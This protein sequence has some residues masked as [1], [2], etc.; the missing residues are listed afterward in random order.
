MAKGNK[1]RKKG[2]AQ[3]SA[4]Y[5]TVKSQF[6][7]LAGLP[8]RTAAKS[9]AIIDENDNEDD[10]NDDLYVE[11]D[12][13][14]VLVTGRVVLTDLPIA[15]SYQLYH[16]WLTRDVSIMQWG[17]DNDIQMIFADNEENDVEVDQNQLGRMKRNFPDEL[18]KARDIMSEPCLE[19]IFGVVRDVNKFEGRLTYRALKKFNNLSSKLEQEAVLFTIVSGAML[20]RVSLRPGDDLEYQIQRITNGNIW[21]FDGVVDLNSHHTIP[22]PGVYAAYLWVANDPHFFEFNTPSAYMLLPRPPNFNTYERFLKGWIKGILQ[23]NVQA[24]RNLRHRPKDNRVYMQNVSAI[25]GSFSPGMA[26]RNLRLGD[27]LKSWWAD[28]EGYRKLLHHVEY[29]LVFEHRRTQCAV[30]CDFEEAAEMNRQAKDFCAQNPML[31]PWIPSPDKRMDLYDPGDPLREKYEREMR[32]QRLREERSLHPQHFHT[33][34]VDENDKGSDND[35]GGHNSDDDESRSSDNRKRRSGTDHSGGAQT[36][37]QNRSMRNA[38]ALSNPRSDPPKSP[39]PVTRQLFATT[40]AVTGMTQG[41][42]GSFSFKSLEDLQRFINSQPTASVGTP[43]NAPASMSSQMVPILTV[44]SKQLRGPDP[45]VPFGPKIYEQLR[46]FKDFLEKANVMLDTPEYFHLR[47]ERIDS[48]WSSHLDLVL[49]YYE[50]PGYWKTLNHVTFFRILFHSLVQAEDTPK[51]TGYVE[52][53]EQWIE[54]EFSKV[55]H[56]NKLWTGNWDNDVKEWQAGASNYLSI[57][58]VTQPDPSDTDPNSQTQT[59]LVKRLRKML[60][61]KAEYFKSQKDYPQFLNFLLDIDE[62]FDKKRVESAKGSDSKVRL[63]RPTSIESPYTAAATVHDYLRTAMIT[64]KTIDRTI[65]EI[66]SKYTSHVRAPVVPPRP[67]VERNTNKPTK[68]TSSSSKGQ[69]KEKQKV[70]PSKEK[71]IAPVATE[72]GEE[73]ENK[74]DKEEPPKQ[75]KCKGCGKRHPDG[76]FLGPDGAN[77][78]DWNNTDKAWKDSTYGPQWEK[79]GKHFLPSNKSLKDPNWVNDK[80]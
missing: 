32:T 56:N 45:G 72:E 30:S 61:G 11:P 5:N 62:E 35:E 74:E 21:N 77:H 18:R 49:F 64:G 55:A 10:D 41:N 3:S 68:E 44:N 24:V 15:E 23:V 52:Q 79:K 27:F 58:Q 26:E 33:S 40:G 34:K 70:N 20:H 29:Y 28:C 67:R 9:L 66:A 80:I 8:T 78:P 1:G 12:G 19:E 53:V 38:G 47:N 76:C 59:L 57:R 75:P 69:Q 13:S 63:A 17:S 43:S 31:E 14:S 39:S 37:L 4:L 42:D 22:H 73:E 6:R 51:V 7:A 54:K 25:H 60:F 65:F 36:I 2:N 71:P 16:T 50:E 46:P 48:V